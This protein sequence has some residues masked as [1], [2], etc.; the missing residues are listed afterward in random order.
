ARAPRSLCFVSPVLCAR[1]ARRLAEPRLRLFELNRGLRQS[2]RGAFTPLCLDFD[3]SLRFGFA[4]RR[5]RL[6]ERR[7]AFLL[8]AI[9]V[10][11]RV[12]SRLRASAPRL[13]SQWRSG[14]SLSAL[15]ECRL[16]SQKPVA[17]TNEIASTT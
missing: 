15:N 9:A 3:K 8:G 1:P 5:F 6:P 12:P 4:P 7:L 13:R 14:K 2:S 11:R 17:G 10:T 16:R